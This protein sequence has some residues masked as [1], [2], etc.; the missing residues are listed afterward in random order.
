[1]KKSN[2]SCHP[3]CDVEITLDLIGGKWK[4]IILYHLLS[5]KIRF[6]Q[7]RKLIPSVT[8]R[9]LT[10]QLRELEQAQIIKRTVY[11]VVPPKVEYELTE[12]GLTL[13]PI[14]LLLK[15]W[16]NDIGKKIVSIQQV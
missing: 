8:Q 14:L 3:A 5:G 12:I 13:K 1:M 6:N 2:D 11:P 7:L 10:N 4:G 16:G 9:M 15:T